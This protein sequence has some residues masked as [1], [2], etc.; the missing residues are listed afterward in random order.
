MTCVL[1]KQITTQTAGSPKFDTKEFKNG[2]WVV[3]EL[4]GDEFDEYYKDFDF[5][6]VNKINCS[7][8]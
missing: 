1:L 3:K 6:N 5:N 7:Y 4:T 8:I 2:E